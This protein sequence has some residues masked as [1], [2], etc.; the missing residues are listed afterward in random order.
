MSEGHTEP[1]SAAGPAPAPAHAPTPARDE[2]D[3]RIDPKRPVIE[4]Q[5]PAGTLHTF[6]QI[7]GAAEDGVLLSELND[8]VTALVKA[9]RDHNLANGGKSAGSLSV[10]MKLTVD[11][12][13]AEMQ[14]DYKLVEP[15]TSRSKTHFFV[16]A[17]GRLTNRNPNQRD[18]FTDAMSRR[19]T[20]A[21]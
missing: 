5:H 12:G 19:E 15:K 13:Q 2:R 9:L 8:E 18:M 21:V 20:I 10:T 6:T 17:T 1:Q 14:V 11:K 16:G 4:P 7:L 3:P